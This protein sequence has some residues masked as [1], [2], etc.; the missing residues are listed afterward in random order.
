LA[1]SRISYDPN[2]FIMLGLYEALWPDFQPAPP[3]RLGQTN[4]L[5]E[6]VSGRLLRMGQ[7][8][9]FGNAYMANCFAQSGEANS[10]IDLTFELY[11]LFGDPEMPVWTAQPANLAVDFPKRMG[12]TGEQDFIVKVIDIANRNPVRSAVVTF[13]SNGQIYDSKMTDAGGIARF[14]WQNPPAGQMD[15]TVTGLGFLPF[16]SSI[17]VTNGGAEI[18]RLDPDN[19][20]AGLTGILIG[21]QSF[22]ANELVDATFG[23]SVLFSKNASSGSYGQ[24]GVEDF[25]FDVPSPYDLGPVNIENYASASDR[26]AVN[27]FQVRTANPIDLYMYS[28]GDESTWFLNPTDNPVWDNPD[29]QLFDASGNAVASNNLVVGN[30]YT[31]RITVRNDTDFPAQGAVVTLLWSNFGIGQPEQIWQDIDTDRIDVP[32]HSTA[33]A[34][35]RW[36]P[37]STGHLCILAKIY[38]IEDINSNN[39]QGQENCH[40]GPTSSPATVSFEV[41][42]PTD[43][44]GMVFM[45]VR[46]VFPDTGSEE[47]LWSSWIKHPEPQLLGPGER[48]SAEITIE[49]GSKIRAGKKAVFS[50]TGYINGVMIGGANF[51][52]ENR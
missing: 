13:V 52:I 41:W 21:A 34:N 37:P 8:L 38:H 17:N 19:G 6:V 12:S 10:F 48:R 49:P 7:L 29:I 39:N 9:N 22:S 42:N 15:L 46:Q 3:L 4:Q 16:Q 43:K 40:V 2:D 30:S 23:G 31:A 33:Q 1:S 32:A 36:V 44:P 18:N 14:T 27:V 11:H 28:Q 24:V 47:I 26:A 20:I 35:I 51:T 5:P 25:A 45:L 50:L